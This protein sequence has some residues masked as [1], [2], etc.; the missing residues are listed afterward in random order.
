[1]KFKYINSNNEEAIYEAIPLTSEI[2]EGII[3]SDRDFLNLVIEGNHPTYF[4]SSYKAAATEMLASYGKGRESTFNSST[5]DLEILLVQNKVNLVKND[6]PV[7]KIS[8]KQELRSHFLSS[9]IR[10]FKVDKMNF[11][12]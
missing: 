9:Q 8:T 4:D 2:Y 11:D 1:M 10:A 5:K 12:I 3:N 6:R 7:K